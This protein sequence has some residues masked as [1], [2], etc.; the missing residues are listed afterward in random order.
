MSTKSTSS[1]VDQLVVG[2][3]KSVKKGEDTFTYETS[4]SLAS[5][6]GTSLGLHDAPKASS[7]GDSSSSASG[8]LDDSFERLHYFG[9][10]DGHGGRHAAQFCA[11]SNWGLAPRTLQHLKKTLA[12]AEANEKVGLGSENGDRGD[13]ILSSS[14]NGKTHGLLKHLPRALTSAFVEAD[15]AFNE[16][17]QPSGTTATLAFVHERIR[18]DTLNGDRIQSCERSVVVANVGD[19][20]C[21]LDDGAHVTAL[22]T[23]HR[24]E[25]SEEER[26]RVIAAGGEIGRAAVEG[27]ACGPPRVWPGGLQMSRTIG[28]GNCADSSIVV[29]HPSVTTR[30]LPNDGARL[31][32]ASDG[33]WD[34]LSG[35]TAARAVR[36][37]PPGHAARHLVK[38]ALKARG[39][40][41]DITVIVVDVPPNP[42]TPT[43]TTTAAAPL[44]A[45]TNGTPAVATAGAPVEMATSADDVPDW[46]RAEQAIL[47]GNFEMMAKTMP[48]QEDTQ[49]ETVPFRS[50][51]AVSAAIAEA[52]S[53]DGEDRVEPPEADGSGRGGRGRGGR[54]GRGARGGGRGRGGRGG[55]GG[56]R[57]KPNAAIAEVQSQDGKDHVVEPEADGSGHGGAGLKNNVGVGWETHA[58]T[59]VVSGIFVYY[60]RDS[61]SYALASEQTRRRRDDAK[62]RKKI[63]GAPD[64]VKQMR[65]DAVANVVNGTHS[66]A[67]HRDPFTG[68]SPED[69]VK[70]VDVVR[71][72]EGISSGDGDDPYEGLSPEEIN[73]LIEQRSSK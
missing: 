71:K 28:D 30:A 72:E 31:I 48:A 6:G 42:P 73:K 59:F 63:D 47:M 4:L 12:L 1:C 55:R 14:E 56:D 60:F 66:F 29:P 57:A 10:F 45:S 33:L 69:I 43:T 32:F 40:R 23:D 46:V 41:D 27:K 67:M 8:G 52:Q 35:K 11:N 15:A 21:Y 24:V 25:N 44:A 38:A 70:F 37:M 34:A 5:P 26:K 19:S 53:Q 3:G 36:K 20:M 64:E 62:W 65:R 2:T 68:M 16:K 13:I 49:W 50:K 58:F 54:G 22:S 17:S 18:K 39:D 9:V 51:N 7:F 61:I